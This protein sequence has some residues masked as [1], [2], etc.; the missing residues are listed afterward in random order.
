MDRLGNMRKEMNLRTT[1]ALLLVLLT[2]SVERGAWSQD[3]PNPKDSVEVL[4]ALEEVKKSLHERIA[5]GVVTVELVRR[6]LPSGLLSALERCTTE[7]QVAPWRRGSI[8]DGELQIWHTWCDSFLNFIE[9]DLFGL[10]EKG[11]LPTIE[12]WSA[13]F[14]RVFD[15]WASQ[16]PAGAEE[17]QET[18][19]R[20]TEGLKANLDGLGKTLERIGVHRG[21]PVI[22]RQSTGFL[23]D[24]GT[25]VT[26]KDVARGLTDNDRIR[27]YSSKQVAYS[28]GEVLG[29][30]PETSIAVIRLASP[31]SDLEP[32]IKFPKEDEPP[33]G[34]FVFTFYHAFHQLSLSMRTG[35][36]T[37]VNRQVPIFHCAT[38]HET[39]LPTSPGTLGAPL[40][41]LNGEL[42]G[43]GNV[44]M[45][46]GTMSEITFAVPA[47]QLR[48]AADQIIQNGCVSRGCMG[49]Y[50]NE[51]VRKG[52]SGRVV[53]VS[54][55][56]PNSPASRSGIRN[57]DIILALNGKEVH[58]RTSLLSA[59]SHYRPNDMITLALERNDESLTV[60]L[61]LAPLAET[62]E[63]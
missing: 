29:D 18:F 53:V 44:F 62:L 13:Y 9:N 24:K 56:V 61:P 22:L 1:N 21:N 49:V 16:G 58:C 4:Q 40:V 45:A 59:L 32:T 42:V 46:Q 15:D 10:S 57:G 2:V 14:G 51:T 39:S 5:D 30:D 54:G 11:T 36:I 27:V 55:L 26:T 37:G 25:V 19:S 20:F 28:T 50:L 3:S 35:E 33:V 7:A 8:T 23:I 31:G 17:I 6:D 34:S 47:L 52:Q 60:Q 12:D 48:A 63:Q 38:F 41:N 43:M